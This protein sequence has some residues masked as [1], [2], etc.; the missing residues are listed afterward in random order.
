[1]LMFDSFLKNSW[2]ASVCTTGPTGEERDSAGYLRS[3]DRLPTAKQVVVKLAVNP[4]TVLKVYQDLEREGLV[5]PQPGPAPSFGGHS[6]RPPRR[7]GTGSL[8]N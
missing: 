6:E 1:M 5:T 3:G 2:G 4:N 7:T 8:K